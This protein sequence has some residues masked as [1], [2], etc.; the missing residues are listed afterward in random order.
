[1]VLTPQ[2]AGV[3]LKKSNLSGSLA[4]RL[5]CYWWQKPLEAFSGGSAGVDR[6]QGDNMG[7]LATMI[8]TLAS[9]LF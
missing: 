8:S 1:M 6:A 7:M 3:T 9:G 4:F 5:P 2:A